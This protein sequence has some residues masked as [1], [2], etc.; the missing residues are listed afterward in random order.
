MLIM[1][2]PDSQVE[3]CGNLPRSH[4]Y[5]WPHIPRS[6]QYHVYVWQSSSKWSFARSPG[7][8]ST[9]SLHVMQ[10]TKA[11]VQQDPASMCFVR[12]HESTLWLFWSCP[13]SNIR[14][15]LRPSHESNRAWIETEWS[16]QSAYKLC[17][18]LLVGSIRQPWTCNSNIYP[19]T[20]NTLAEYAKPV[21]C[22]CISR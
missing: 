15:L 12:A 2:S 9:T 7:S 11:K 4:Y 3:A 20:R 10:K 5:Q 18:T 14:G 6:L 19:S 21:P 16:A 13:S 8:Q 17:D 1:T 22:H